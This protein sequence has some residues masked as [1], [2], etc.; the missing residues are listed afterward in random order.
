MAAYRLK[1]RTYVDLPVTANT[2]QA[3][4]AAVLNDPTVG[5]VVLEFT[6]DGPMWS[7]AY[8]VPGKGQYSC[9]GTAG[10]YLRLER[11]PAGAPAKLTV[12]AVPL[13]GDDQCEPIISAPRFQHTAQDLGDMLA[14]DTVTVVLAWPEPFTD[15]SYTCWTEPR[16]GVV[17]T[18]VNDNPATVEVTVKAVVDTDAAS[19]RVYGHGV[20]A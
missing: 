14:G 9:N 18:A 16:G 13:S 4:V 19:V 8:V 12:S 2:T 5:A 3:D 15:T 10:A 6:W 11:D 17:V 7:L 20:I 1:D